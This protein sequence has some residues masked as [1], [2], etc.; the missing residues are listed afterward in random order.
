MSRTPQDLPSRFLKLAELED[1][2]G[3]SFQTI[4]ATV[5]ECTEVAD[6]RVAARVP[7]VSVVILSY[8]HGPY[9][10]QALEGAARQKTD[11]PFELI[12]AEDCSTDGTRALAL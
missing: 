10:R 11:F 7:R 5:C 8:N 2:R 1:L 9:L 3:E 12:V 6:P 4:D